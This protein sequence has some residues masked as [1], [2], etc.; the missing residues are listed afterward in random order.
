MNG[1]DFLKTIRGSAK[2]TKGVAITWSTV[3]KGLVVVALVAEHESIL[4]SSLF[5][6]F[7]V[8]L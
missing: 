6:S 3:E 2:S 1:C 4:G 8:G 5:L 7:I